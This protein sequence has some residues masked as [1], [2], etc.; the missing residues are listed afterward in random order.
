ML[1]LSRYT[2]RQ[3]IAGGFV[4]PA[5]G[6]GNAWQFDFRD[7]VLLRVAHDLRAGRIPTRRI[8][9]SLARLRAG[10]PES[11]PLSGLRITAVGDQVAVR[12]RR[13]TWD[14]ETGQLLIDLD[15]GLD[16]PPPAV[17]ALAAGSPETESTSSVHEPPS[18]GR[19]HHARNQP[20]TGRDRL[21]RAASDIDAIE[22]FLAAEAAEDHDRSAAERGYRRAIERDPTLADAVLN[23]SALLCDSGRFSAAMGVLDRGLRHRPDVA[24]LYFNRGV[25]L[26]DLGRQGE[27]IASYEASLRVDPSLADAHYN[28]A[29]LHELAGD[30]RRA[31]R[32]LSSYRRLT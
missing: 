27:A 9:R 22:T 24:L 18:A 23:L 12:R 19:K 5:R 26:E 6:R 3:L 16:G 1:G 32:H 14:A 7:I 29:R 21:D 30:R 2:I 8:M 4:K 15:L 31:L 10:L 28:L 20:P 17:T 25:A 13:E 11:M